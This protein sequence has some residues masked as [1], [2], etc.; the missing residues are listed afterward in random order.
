[1]RRTVIQMLA[2]VLVLW[3]VFTANHTF[4]EHAVPT[5]TTEEASIDL[6][7]LMYH[8]I[9]KDSARSGKYVLSPD[10]L[11]KD[12]DYLKIAGYQTITVGDLVAYVDSGTPL[13]A[14]PVMITFDDGYY[15]NYVYAYPIL[16]ERKM[17]AVVSIIGKQTALFSENGQENPYWSHLT[18]DRL[19]EMSDVFEVQNHSWD[20]HA[21]GHRRGCIRE[22]GEDQATYRAFFEHDTQ[23]TQQMLTDAGLPAP[24]CYTY[25]FGS[26]STESEGLLR[27]MGFRSTLGCEE[28]INHITR[29]PE[30]LY[31]MKRY[32]RPS[33]ML[34]HTFMKKIGA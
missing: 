34:T 22:R 1:M 31:R 12:L 2:T 16:K 28:G 27:S 23:Q 18:T 3:G 15:N 21:Y 14:K 25:P 11:A 6:P 4:V 17:C 29:D 33:G 9:L 10:A 32:N 24:T 26:L 30:C 19:H 13:P 7:I 20:L 8:S 5:A